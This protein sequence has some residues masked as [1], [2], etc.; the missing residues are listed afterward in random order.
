MRHCTQ[1]SNRYAIA[2]GPIA[3][4]PKAAPVTSGHKATLHSLQKAES[5]NQMRGSPSLP[6]TWVTACDGGPTQYLATLVVSEDSMSGTGG[7][8][9]LLLATRT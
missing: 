6:S 2:I 7:A 5:T 8:V 1:P 4:Y 9:L 3:A